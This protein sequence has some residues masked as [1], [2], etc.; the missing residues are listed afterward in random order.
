[1]KS[2]QNQMPKVNKKCCTESGHVSYL[3]KEKI[4]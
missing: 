1:M 2:A 3:N 4:Y